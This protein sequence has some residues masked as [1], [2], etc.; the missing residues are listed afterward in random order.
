M[1]DVHHGHGN[2]RVWLVKSDGALGRELQA[3]SRRPFAVSR[4]RHLQRPE[5]G[6]HPCRKLLAV[7]CRLSSSSRRHRPSPHAALTV[8]IES[9]VPV[10]SPA[11]QRRRGYMAQMTARRMMR[12]A[13]APISK[14]AHGLPP[15]NSRKTTCT[16]SSSILRGQEMPAKSAA[17]SFSSSFRIHRSSLRPCPSAIHLTSFSLHVYP[18]RSCR[19]RCGLR[20]DSQMGGVPHLSGPLTFCHPILPRYLTRFSPRMIFPMG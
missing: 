3:E 19:A 15:D 5:S 17:S 9:R 6:S 14:T 12:N 13:I 18:G 20:V 8:R 4:Q 16:R 10:S 2:S 7:S 11:L 1:V